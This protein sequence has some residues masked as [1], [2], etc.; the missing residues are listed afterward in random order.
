MA[1]QNA[2]MINPFE[3]L[4]IG[5]KRA[6]AG[7]EAGQQAAE[8]EVLNELYAQ[9]VDPRT[10]QVDVNKLYAGLAARRMGSA[11]PGMQAQRAEISFKEAQ[12]AKQR[13]EAD[14]LF[15]EGA[16]NELAAL[17]ENNQAGYQAWANRVLE[18]APWAVKYLAPVLNPETKRQMLMTADAALPKGEVRDIG[19]GTATID[20]FTGKQIGATVMNVPE[21]EDVIRSKERIAKAGASRTVIGPA[22]SERSKTV[23]KLGGETLVNEYNAA[24]SASRGLARDYETLDL[25]R[26]GKPATGITSELE[27]NIARFRSKVGK[28]PESIRT[29]A[30]SQLLEA[31]LGSQV[32]EQIQALGVGARG[33]DTPAEREFLREVIA[34]TRKLDK[35][36]LIRMAEMRA[37]YK[38]DL[39]NDYN[40]RIESGELDQFFTDFGKPKRAFN[41]PKR[42][43]ETAT[44]GPQTFATEAQ[45]EAA[46]KAGKIKRG[47]RVTIGGVTGRW[48]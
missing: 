35:D 31:L 47:D 22:E 32:F 29:A 33:L 39:V 38:E 48:E 43:Q 21:S 26:K 44:A 11:I 20:P 30:D 1:D 46:F 19:G 36:T 7:Y 8:R 16:R 6:Y 17:P 27:T 23:G 34:G 40:S 37:K 42:P 41:V 45:A 15:W 12:A 13:E 24:A 10:G 4:D 9:A 18:R 5:R 3:S 25:L 28:D 14:K 2:L